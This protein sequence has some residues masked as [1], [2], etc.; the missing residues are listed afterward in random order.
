[1]ASSYRNM[2][3]ATLDSVRFRWEVAANYGDVRALTALYA[4]DAIF[5]AATGS[6][7]KGSGSIDAV[8]ARWLS[9]AHNFHLTTDSFYAS[10]DII[11]AITSMSYDADWPIGGSFSV[12]DRVTFVLRRGAHDRWFVQAQSGGG[13][14]VVARAREVAE[15]TGAGAEETLAVRVTDA[16]G[17]AVAS[18]IVAFR[19][20]VG[21][22]TFEPSAALTDMQGVARTVFRLGRTPGRY[23]VRATASIAPDDP[24]FFSMMAGSDASPPPGDSDAAMSGASPPR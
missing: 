24:Q 18:S 11:V 13:L 6:L 9:R 12:T 17:A 7:V 22:G 20:E 10:G 14:P 23:V 3:A 8:V 21:V 2:V 1:M 4:S 19:N 16:T 15:Q 5:V